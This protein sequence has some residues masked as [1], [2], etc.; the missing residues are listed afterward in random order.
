MEISATTFVWMRDVGCMTTAHVTTSRQKGMLA[1]TNAGV[2]LLLAGH[3]IVRLLQHYCCYRFDTPQS[4][5]PEDGETPAAKRHNWSIISKILKDALTYELSWE[6][7]ELIVQ[8]DIVEVI[9]LLKQIQDL[10][11]QHRRADYEQRLRHR[12]MA[13]EPHRV[14]IAARLCKPFTIGE[15]RSPSPHAKPWLHNAS[16]KPPAKLPPLPP[17]LP[18][19]VK[20][21]LPPEA[22]CPVKSQT[23]EPIAASE[24]QRQPAAR[25]RTPEP[26]RRVQRAPEI[27]EA[28]L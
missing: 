8:G 3:S 12:I 23:P 2:H 7:R 1:L 16:K 28:D 25:R 15:T 22:R 20:P 4:L 14:D 18:K 5:Q 11:A 27:T 17:K 10:V 26:A 9:V 24:D 13:E 19:Q 6:R 21:R